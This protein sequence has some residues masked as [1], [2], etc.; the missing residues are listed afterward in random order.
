MASYSY[1]LG[2]K[3]VAIL[4]SRHESFEA[5]KFHGFHAF[6]HFHKTFLYESSRWCCLSMDLRDSVNVFHEGLH[7]QLAA[8]LFC[9][10]TFMVCGYIALAIHSNNFIIILMVG[11]LHDNHIHI[12][13]VI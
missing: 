4:Y 10:E 13:V 9:L 8:K 3:S 2:L 6:M 1:S 5:E 7:V 11:T 12:H